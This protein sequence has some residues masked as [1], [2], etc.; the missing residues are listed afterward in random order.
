MDIGS[1]STVAVDFST[2][3]FQT[4]KDHVVLIAEDNVTETPHNFDDEMVMRTLLVFGADAV[5]R[6]QLNDTLPAGLLYSFYARALE[7]FTQ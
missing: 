1:N 4:A 6:Y 7:V 2:N 5:A 3:T